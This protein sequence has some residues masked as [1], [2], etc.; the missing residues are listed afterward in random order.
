VS[1][2]EIAE[3]GA[4]WAADYRLDRGRG[5]FA[6]IDGRRFEPMETAALFAREGLA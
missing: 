6:R 5:E 1:L 3:K 4:A 2:A